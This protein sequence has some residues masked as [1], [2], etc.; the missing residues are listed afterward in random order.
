MN[1]HEIFFAGIFIFGVLA[2]LTF[3][4]FTS[5]N[6]SWEHSEVILKYFFT[7]PYPLNG[8]QKEEYTPN[9]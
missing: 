9:T 3:E 1:E 6:N 4:I 2:S 7:L 5:T 8:L